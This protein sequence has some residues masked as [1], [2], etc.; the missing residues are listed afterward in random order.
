MFGAIVLLLIFPILLFHI[1]DVMALYI[2]RR[3]TAVQKKLVQ[4]KLK[5]QL[6]Q[7]ICPTCNCKLEKLAGEK[8]NVYAC[9]KCNATIILGRIVPKN[10][11][12]VQLSAIKLIDRSEERQK[13]KYDYRN[14]VEDAAQEVSAVVATIRRAMTETKLL[15]FDYP[16]DKSMVGRVTEPYKLA[17][18]GGNNLVL[19][20]YC[21]EAEGIRMFKLDKIRNVAVQEYAYKPRW[22]I[23]DKVE[24]GK[25]EKKDKGK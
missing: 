12:E 22:D 8:D 1:G 15:Q 16:R 24:N 2:R 3:R 20:A 25:D 5:N 6:D 11:K 9:N 23:E 19:W 10:S 14:R 18:D 13:K 4:Q 17:V 21:T 7:R